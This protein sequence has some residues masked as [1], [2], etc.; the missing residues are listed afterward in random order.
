MNNKAVAFKIVFIGDTGVGKTSIISKFNK[1][2]FKN[3]THS[4]IGADFNSSEHKTPNGNAI[5][6]HLWDT[7]GQE[8]YRAIV[9]LYF[10]S[11]HVIVF[12]F[13]LA[14]IESLKNIEHWYNVYDKEKDISFK[15]APLLILIGNKCDSD[16]RAHGMKELVENYVREYGFTYFETSAKTGEHINVVFDHIKKILS[17]EYDKS[18]TNTFNKVSN[19]DQLETLDI[20][21]EYYVKRQ[22]CLY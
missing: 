17:D 11:A 12:V 9:G 4:T 16:N 7:A 3:I 13:D 14:R 19:D 5:S 15:V 10:R 8:K 18:N 6:L 2:V 20:N 1:D 21:N 22:C